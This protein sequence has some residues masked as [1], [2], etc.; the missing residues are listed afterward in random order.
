MI[1][2]NFSRTFHIQSRVLVVR[3]ESVDTK[4]LTLFSFPAS[5]G[6]SFQSL[7]TVVVRP[8]VNTMIPAWIS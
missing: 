1:G 7:N 3:F 8:S 6:D 4:H 5:F 2:V